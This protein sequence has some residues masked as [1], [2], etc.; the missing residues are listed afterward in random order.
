MTDHDFAEGIER[1]E[2]AVKDWWRKVV[3]V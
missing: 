2:E 1:G 3:G